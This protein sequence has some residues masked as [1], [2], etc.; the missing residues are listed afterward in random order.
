M[1]YVKEIEIHSVETVSEVSQKSR[2]K[3]M[4]YVRKT[5]SK[6]KANLKKH[7]RKSP[8]TQSKELNEKLRTNVPDQKIN[9]TIPAK[10]TK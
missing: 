2:V 6:G 1:Q 7:S 8:A 3:I 5:W 10:K 4:T 9:W